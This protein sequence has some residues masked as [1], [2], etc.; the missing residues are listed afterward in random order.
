MKPWYK[1]ILTYVAFALCYMNTSE[2]EDLNISGLCFWWVIPDISMKKTYHDL[3]QFISQIPDIFS[4]NLY[5]YR[6]T[7]SID[8]CDKVRKACSSTERIYTFRLWYGLRTVLSLASFFYYC[9]QDR[10]FRNFDKI[11]VRLYDN[12]KM[13]FAPLDR[14]LSTSQ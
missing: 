8:I 11:S 13:S 4:R 2:T 9:P 7:Q 14:D 12:R 3:Y 5:S 10:I 1:I 6:M